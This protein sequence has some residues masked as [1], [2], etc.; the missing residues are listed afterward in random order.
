MHTNDFKFILLGAVLLVNPM[1]ACHLPY[2]ADFKLD[3]ASNVAA[4]NRARSKRQPTNCTSGKIA[5]D[6][7]GVF[8]GYKIQSPRT[9]VIEGSV[10]GSDPS[11]AEHIDGEGAVLLPGL[12]D[13][14]CHPGNVTHLKSLAQY[15]VTTG[16][17]M[18][19]FTSE[20]C[21]SL[22]NHHGLPTILISSAPATAPNSVHGNITSIVDRTL[23]V[24]SSSQIPTWMKE[25][26]ALNPNYIKLV[27]EVPG[28]DQQM[29]NALVDEAHAYSKQTVMHASGFEAYNQSIIARSDHVHHAPLDK[30]IS[31]SMAE[32][33]L[34]QN[35]VVTPTLTMMRAVAQ[36][37][38]DIT[39]YMAAFKTVR[40]LHE[41][42]VPILA[43]TDANLQP[44]VPAMVPF[45][46]SMHD[47][48]ENLVE[49][50]FSNSEALR[51]ATVLPAL[52]FGLKDRGA[53]KVGMRADLILVEGNPLVDIRAIRNIKRVW[54]GGAE[55][56]N[57]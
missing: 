45:G 9:V 19:C 49:A 31:L 41:V 26:A 29:L 21:T 30:E 14:H 44:G 18:T 37:R 46:I 43:G 22:N 4:N 42:G 51:A 15:G 33:M 7:V 25:Q 23:L 8:D 12:I 38:T 6:N 20:Q 2:D 5:L 53:I 10:I 16:F 56:A 11:G 54:V 35:Q 34:Y 55:Y 57:S 52:H 13:S 40:M 48:L 50:G 3:L 24:N 27:A 47:E 36:S 28:F 32:T 1:T 17:I 39:N